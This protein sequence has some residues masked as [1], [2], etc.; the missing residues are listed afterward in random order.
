MSEAV[1][2]LGNLF[3]AQEKTRRR[4]AEYEAASAHLTIA[5]REER[6][7]ELLSQCEPIASLNIAREDLRKVFKY[8]WNGGEV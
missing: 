8:I 5:R 2:D 4:M 6:M 1:H 7:R 3:Q